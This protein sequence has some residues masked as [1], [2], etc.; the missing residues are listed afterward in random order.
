MKATKA[1]TKPKE[2]GELRMKSDDFD[3]IMR[4]ALGVAPEPK[5]KPKPRARKKR[6]T[7]AAP[8]RR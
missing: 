4:G 2:L 1:K 6:A 3:K 5:A 7:K 8:G